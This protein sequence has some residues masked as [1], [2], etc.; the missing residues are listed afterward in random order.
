[1]SLASGHTEDL[2]RGVL[3]DYARGLSVGATLQDR[4]APE[5]QPAE[6][7]AEAGVPVM[8][9]AELASIGAG[10]AMSALD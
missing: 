8:A 10:A 1:M 7:E 6:A 3:L 4:A 2:L 5:G 9:P